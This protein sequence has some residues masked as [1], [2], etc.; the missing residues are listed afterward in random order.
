MSAAGGKSG[1]A[2]GKAKR[3]SAF[4]KA[5][6]GVE[7]HGRVSEIRDHHDDSGNVRMSVKHGKRTPGGDGIFDTYQDE[8]SFT[9]P[10][11]AAKQFPHGSRVKVRVHPHTEP[12]KKKG[13]GRQL[14]AD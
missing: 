10:K 12:A 4:K 1:P 6:S 9:I 5:G 14:L 2:K 8:S 13:K 11:E 3:K 7:A